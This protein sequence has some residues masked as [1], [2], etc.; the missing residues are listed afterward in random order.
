MSVGDDEVTPATA[1]PV[2][3]EGVAALDYQGGTYALG[4]TSGGYATW[5]LTAGGDPV[6]VFAAESWVDAWTA[7]QDLESRRV[8]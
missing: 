2:P 8:R 7:L 6:R 3:Q 1:A 4:R 5:D